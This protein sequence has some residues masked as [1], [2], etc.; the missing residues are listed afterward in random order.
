MSVDTFVFPTSFAQRR[1]WFVHQLEPDSPSYNVTTALWLS[2]DL[3]VPALERSLA[4]LV[5]RHETLRT[6][7]RLAEGEPVQAV[8]PELR[9]ELPVADRSA[10]PV[11]DREAEVQRLIQE[12]ARRP[13]ELERGPLLRARL[14]RLAPDEH[15]L[16]LIVHHIVFDGWSA[17]VLSRELSECYRAFSTGEAPRLPELP[18]Q[19]ADYAVWQR[20][21]LTGEPFE[22]QLA[23][24]RT[25]L[26]GAPAVLELPTDF[27]RPRVQ[28]S[29][30]ATEKR[31][32]SRGLLEKLTALSQQEGA[33]LFMTLLAGFQ[34]LLS[35]YTGQEDIVVGSPIANRTRSEL[36]HL[37]GFFVNSLALRTDVSGDPSFR[38]LLRRVRGVAIGAYA[39]QDI[40]F[41]GLVGELRPERVGDRNPFFQVMFVLQ[42]APRTKLTLPGIRLRSL[43]RRTGTS[44]FD[45]TLHMHQLSQGLTASLEYNTDLFEPGTIT[46]MLSHLERLFEEVVAD[47]DRRLSAISL[48]TADQRREMLVEWNR[49]DRVF[50]A[51]RCVH[52]LFESQA[53][54]RPDAAAV[55][56][57]SECLTYGELN[58]RANRVAR[59]L[60]RRGVGPEVRVGVALERSAD[61]VV[62]LL[63]VL[64]SGGAYVPLDPSHPSERLGLILKDAGVSL[65]LTRAG[66][67]P[68]LPAALSVLGLDSDR[69]RIEEESDENLEH[70]ASAENLAYVMYTSGSTGRPKGIAI[71]HRAIA[72]LVC[73]TDYAQLTAADR[74]AQ[75]SNASFDAATFEL[76]GALLNG[77][78]LVI[79]PR[80]V[81]LSPGAFAAEIRERGIS[82]M[83][84]TTTLFNQLVSEVP[85]VFLSVRHVLFGGEAADPRSVRAV[86]AKGRP[87]RLLNAYGPTEATTFATWQ[88]VREVAE[89]AL[90]VPI[91]VPIANT[92]AYV[93]DR[94]LEPVPLGIPGELYLGGPGLARGYL[95]R[96]ALTAERF[97]PDPFRAELG[98]RLYRTGDRVRRRADGTLEFM[99][100]IDGQIKLRGFRIEPGEIESVLAKHPAVRD[101][102]VVLRDDPPGRRELV[103]YLV[104]RVTSTNGSRVSAT[105]LRNHLRAALP[106]YMVPSAFVVLEALPLSPNG[107]LDRRA[108]PPPERRGDSEVSFVPPATPVEK[109]LARQWQELLGVEPVGLGDNFFE[110][111][112]HSLLAVKLFAEIERVFGRRLP[113][114]T[115]FQ[116]STL[117]QL[118]EVLSQTPGPDSDSTLALLRRGKGSSPPLFMVHLHYGD[119]ME[120]RELVSR[121][122]PD[123]TVYGCEAPVGGPEEPALRTLEELA[124]YHVR[125]IRQRQPTGP[126]LLCGLCWAGLVAFEMASQLREAGAEVSLLALI[127]SP[128]PGADRAQPIH[129]RA[130]SRVRK[131]WRLTV[132]NLR[133]LGA[134]EPQAVPGFLRQRLVNI[135]MRVAGVTAFRWSV[136]FQRALLP[137]FREMPKA[138]LHAGWGY[139]PRPYPGRITLFRAVGNGSRR[140]A[141]PFA[142]WSQVA[143]GGVEVYE[144][145]GGHNTMMRE[146]HVESL[147]TQL[148]ACLERI[149][150][151]ARR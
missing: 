149:R 46:R 125:Q 93:L 134:L 43:P 72:R 97:V 49:T 144:V 36:E 24:W 10:V 82:A 30:G 118:A 68:N 29:R 145:A 42:N 77:A 51:D 109:A 13:F 80:D 64:K 129:H 26:A 25:Q 115:L 31:L 96:P 47:P 41:E 58:R 21:W 120:Y 12:E 119:V 71:P 20:E 9:L 127:D 45:I 121:L 66:V 94:H 23:Y 78:R 113:L 69:A 19:Y 4:T 98:G 141:D 15:A 40:P 53:A 18:V 101:C 143:A 148:Q 89:E 131:V 116:A 150:S 54:H 27:P 74:V 132:Q 60:R 39:H 50:P 3:D 146:P 11:P 147:A 37:I 14:I 56:D 8:A 87:E 137:A 65:L 110:L 91:G 5:A 133:R 33:T 105:D 16:I 81:T 28:S 140:G 22:R 34:L 76:W 52:Q 63:A 35:R 95:G 7:F 38:E 75:V 100:R 83:F 32:L 61:L 92:R 122:Q 138:L 88:L 73:N 135:V 79:I 130:R 128:Y 107:K 70:Q 151:E 139:R 112:G 103:A 57:G 6:T 55:E 84:L 111:G 86:L 136:R 99:G 1:L 117:G 44:K 106:E 59:F 2:G 114:S 85:D 102:L 142:G 104:P 123:Q 48:L 108:L 17:G 90:T 67:L 126:Y 62:A 124:S